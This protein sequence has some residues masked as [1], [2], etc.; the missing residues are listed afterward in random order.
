MGELF[1]WDRFFENIP[2]IVPY[3]SVTFAI[4][5][6]ATVLGVLLGI[7]IAFV[8]MKKIPVLH[9]FFKVYVSFMRGTPM[10]VQLMLVYYGLPV[11]IDSAFGTNINREWSAIT[12]AYITFILNQGAFLSAIFYS[13]ITSIPYGQTEAG[14]SVGL[15]EIQTFKRIILPQMVRVALPP[16]GSD[17]VG[18]FQNSSLVFLIGVTD[19]MGRAKTIGTATKHVLEAYVFVAIVYIIISLIVRGL[20]KYLNDKFEFGKARKTIMLDEI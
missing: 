18:L 1:K 7:V 6:F 20:F 9:Q 12:F 15:T 17:L 2:K 8:N 10:L 14:L 19:I 3:L 11:L 13:A 16:F 4:V 5:I